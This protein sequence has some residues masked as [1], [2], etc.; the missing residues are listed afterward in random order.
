MLVIG[1]GIAGIMAAKTAAKNNLKTLILDEKTEIGGTT[2]YQNSEN[3]KIDNKIS[4]DWLNN[5][6]N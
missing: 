1:A 3:F 5:E 4:S 6:I 2:I